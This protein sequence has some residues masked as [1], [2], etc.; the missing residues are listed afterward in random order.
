[1]PNKIYAET[2]DVERLVSV[3]AGPG[4]EETTLT[5][6]REGNGILAA[7]ADDDDIQQLTVAST[8]LGMVRRYTK[9]F[10][11]HRRRGT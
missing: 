7:F 4:R 6:L 10:T 5:E 2:V 8:N 1:M 11:K 9:R 3:I